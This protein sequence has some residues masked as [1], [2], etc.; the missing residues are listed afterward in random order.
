[1][2]SLN[3][4]RWLFWCSLISI[5]SG[6]QRTPH[7]DSSVVTF[8]RIVEKT[9][10]PCKD[11]YLNYFTEK[12]NHYIKLKELFLARIGKLWMSTNIYPTTSY[13]LSF[14]Y[15]AKYQLTCTA[16][17]L[18]SST[19]EVWL[20]GGLQSFILD[21]GRTISRSIIVLYLGILLELSGVLHQV[22]SCSTSDYAYS[23]PPTATNIINNQFTLQNLVQW[24]LFYLKSARPRFF[25]ISENCGQ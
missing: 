8:S 10:Y 23:C 20:S 25:R 2:F 5:M 16:T 11:E 18:M 21:G 14:H 22:K 6:C 17:P 12:K 13:L 24:K 19:M 4:L 9:E 1:M 15:C 7:S 3:L